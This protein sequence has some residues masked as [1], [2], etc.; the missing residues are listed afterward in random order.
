MSQSDETTPPAPDLE[1][2]YPPRPGG[3]VDT[4]RKHNA[5]QQ[6][7]AQAQ[8]ARDAQP[9]PRKVRPVTV[10]DRQPGEWGARTVT[11][12]PGASL[13][14]M[15]ADEHR[16]RGKVNLLTAAAAVLI[17][18]DRSAADSGTGYTLLSGQ[19]PEEFGHTREVWLA[20]PGADAI[21]VS[22]YTESYVRE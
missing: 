18:K 22:V 13:M 9:A 10:K 8:A 12:I 19:P 7:A 14:A 15:A 17:A 21:Q 20:N 4:T 5:R 1:E 6:A 16:K 2:L 3:L 11:L